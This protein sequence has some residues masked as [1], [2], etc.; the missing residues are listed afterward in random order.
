MC[1]Y[2][3]YLAV[4]V[5]VVSM[6]FPILADTVAGPAA[7]DAQSDSQTYT[8]ND[9]GFYTA[10]PA[11]NS[12]QL[13]TLLRNYQTALVQRG[14]EITRYLDE[15]QLDVTDALITVIMP[16]G[17][18]YAAVRKANIEEARDEL[19]EITESMDELAR[20]LLVMQAEAGELTLARLN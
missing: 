3:F 5:S 4:F 15:N 17:L 13:I 6:S 18:V 8:A 19:T 14:K 7:T 1:R 12:N 16:G 10:L 9:G 20:D 11:V 2:Y